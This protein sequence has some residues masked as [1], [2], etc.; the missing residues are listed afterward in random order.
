MAGSA[1]TLTSVRLPYFDNNVIGE[2]LTAITGDDANGTVPTLV[3]DFPQDCEL[4]QIETN[5]GSTGPTADWDVTLIDSD[6]AD[7]LD[8]SGQD[9][10]TSSTLVD[11]IIWGST[12]LHPVIKSGTYT[13][14]V[15]N[16]SVNSATAT[17]AIRWRPL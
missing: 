15:A 11:P 1:H 7:V 2:H 3:L 4:L 13:L 5:P 10:H 8:G 12:S 9:R 6:G 14:T 16:T 17:I